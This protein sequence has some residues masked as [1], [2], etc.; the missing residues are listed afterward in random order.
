[1]FKK[2]RDGL[3]WPR[4]T[5][6]QDQGEQDAPHQVALRGE[7]A[8]QGLLRDTGALGDARRGG[9]VYATLADQRHRRLNDRP[10]LF[11]C[12]RLELLRLA[13]QVAQRDG[14]LLGHAP[15]L[16]S[17]RAGIA[18]TLLAAIKFV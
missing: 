5:A 14:L 10:L 11:G 18:S 1:A 3:P 16:T 13:L 4:Q 7:V 15:I 9:T 12:R 6:L 17:P 8:K 2:H